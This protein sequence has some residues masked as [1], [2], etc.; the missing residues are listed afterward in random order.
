MGC[1]LFIA[2]AGL[3]TACACEPAIFLKR[4]YRSSGIPEKAIR[5]VRTIGFLLLL[6]AFLFLMLVLI[7]SRA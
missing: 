5:T 2:L 6:S 3:G 4:K 1:F 7:S